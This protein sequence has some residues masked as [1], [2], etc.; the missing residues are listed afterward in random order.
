M[1]EITENK[2]KK[3]ILEILKGADL[4]SI[5]AKKVRKELEEKYDEDLLEKKQQIDDL[6]M[7]CLEEMEEKEAHDSSASEPEEAASDDDEPKLKKK[8]KNQSDSDWDGDDD[9]EAPKKP[10]A[11]PKKKA[12]A[13]T[14]DKPEKAVK[15]KTGY[16]ADL[17]LSEALAKVVGAE[18]LPRSEVVKRMWGYVKEKN[19]QDPRNKQFT[20]CDD[21]L[22][23]VF[24]KFPFMIFFPER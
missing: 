9:D 2:L 11:K 20:L 13:T 24:G 3:D 15:K 5:S 21:A 16:N 1:S 4:N 14:N 17:V 18:K 19:L 12:A 6:V 10:K 8:K 23:E 7:A 22:Q